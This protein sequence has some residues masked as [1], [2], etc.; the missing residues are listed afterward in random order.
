MAEAAS[1]TPK[2]AK[3]REFLL[4]TAIY[5]NKPAKALS[6]LDGGFFPHI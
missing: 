5:N 1:S 2:P 6:H 4:C 3:D